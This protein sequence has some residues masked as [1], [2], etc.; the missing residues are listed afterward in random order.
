M[1]RHVKKFDEIDRP[2]LGGDGS[3][4]PSTTSSLGPQ[5]GCC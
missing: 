1:V 4:V 5:R 2:A 3:K